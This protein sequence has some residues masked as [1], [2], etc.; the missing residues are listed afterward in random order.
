MCRSHTVEHGRSGGATFAPR[1]RTLMTR[2]FDALLDGTLLT[3]IVIGMAFVT[4]GAAVAGFG[5]V[6]AHAARYADVVEVLDTGLDTVRIVA[7]APGT[8]LGKALEP[9]DKGEGLI[10]IYVTLQ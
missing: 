9:L 2:V 3:G 6:S 5:F 8:V 1:V 7:A 10:Y 4:T